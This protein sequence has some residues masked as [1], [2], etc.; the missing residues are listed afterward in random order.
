MENY[1]GNGS[2]NDNESETKASWNVLMKLFS[3]EFDRVKSTATLKLVRSVSTAVS[4]LEAGKGKSF[5]KSSNVF[6]KRLK[7][8][9]IVLKLCQ[10][11][12]AQLKDYL[13]LMKQY[14]ER[15][16]RASQEDIQKDTLGTKL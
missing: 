5:S 14:N 1:T 16:A 9:S 6:G 12:I 7:D 10:S 4:K 3:D 15:S 2:G 13:G 8:D 11:Y